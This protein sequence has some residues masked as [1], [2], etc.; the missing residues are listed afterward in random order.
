[1]IAGASEIRPRSARSA[2]HQPGDAAE[3]G[4][5]DALCQHLR[6]D[7]AAR[8]PPAKCGWRSRAAARMPSQAAGWRH[9][10]TQSAAPRRPRPSSTSSAGRTVA[11]QVFE[12]GVYGRGLVGVEVGILLRRG[13]RRWSEIRRAR[14]PAARRPSAARSRAV[15]GSRGALSWR[16]RARAATTSSACAGYSKPARHH[17]DH[18]ARAPID[19]DLAAHNA[20]VARRS[21]AAT[22]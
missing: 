18:G 21:A 4:E 7:R 9:S 6:Q 10:R 17:A 22:R 16:R 20:R 14:A 19:I 3:H 13:R 1:M 8:R 11:H 2:M 12:H 15:G 5:H